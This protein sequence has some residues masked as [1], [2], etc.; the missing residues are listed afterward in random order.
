MQGEGIARETI[1]ISMLAAVLGGL[2]FQVPIGRLSDGFDRR[3][4]LAALGLGVAGTSL[5][6]PPAPLLTGGLA[7]RGVTWR[8]YVDPLSSLRRHDQL[9]ADRVVALSSQLILVSGLGSVIGP[10]IGAN[11]MGR[12]SID[13]VFYFMGAA[14]LLLAVLAAGRSLTRASPQHRE[15]PF[16]ILAPQAA[17]LAHDPLGA[18][19]GFPSPAPVGLVS[20]R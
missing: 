12:F 3:I 6:R 20:S 4:V 18:S 1:A 5:A 19:D 8:V 2:A 16:E 17:L 7:G 10:L 9:P 14:A 11:L 13:G 15:R